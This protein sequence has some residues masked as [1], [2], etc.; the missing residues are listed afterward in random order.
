MW[1]ALKS[2]WFASFL[3]LFSIHLLSCIEDFKWLNSFNLIL[4]LNTVSLIPDQLMRKHSP[5]NAASFPSKTSFW[6]YTYVYQN[7]IICHRNCLSL[8]P[9]FPSGQSSK[10]IVSLRSL[11]VFVSFY[12]GKFHWLLWKLYVRSLK[13]WNFF[14]IQ[15]FYR[16]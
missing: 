15:Y 14:N 11:F 12:F 6:T 5:R 10:I 9:I 16:I 4:R 7:L 1:N 2:F 3:L 8:H 13:A